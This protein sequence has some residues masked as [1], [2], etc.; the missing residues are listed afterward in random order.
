[1]VNIRIADN[2]IG[3]DEQKFETILQPFKRLHGRSQY[4]GSGMGLAIVKKIIDRHRGE[5]AVQ[6]TPGVGST[7]IVTLPITQTG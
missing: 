4:E 3:F 1:M 7:F 6:S 2:G 5:I